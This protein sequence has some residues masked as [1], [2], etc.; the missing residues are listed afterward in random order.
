M[1]G[2]AQ[3]I[4]SLLLSGM[5]A[6]LKDSPQQ[7]WTPLHYAAFKGH[8]AAIDALL[9]G[10][11]NPNSPD[12][13]QW[14]PAHI[15]A[16]EGQTAALLA[17]LRGGASSDSRTGN[18]NTPLHVAAQEG[19]AQVVGVLLR[20][21]P[22]SLTSA[23][24][25]G[26][27][28]L[29]C[30][31]YKGR[32]AA[33]QALLGA[34]ASATAVDNCGDAPLHRT[35]AGWQKEELQQYICTAKALLEAG[36]DPAAANQQ[37]QTPLALASSRG[38]GPLLK[39]LAEELGPQG[40]GNAAGMTGTRPNV[41]GGLVGLQGPSETKRNLPDGNGEEGISCQPRCDDSACAAAGSLAGWFL[42]CHAC[43]FC[44][45]QQVKL[46]STPLHHLNP[47]RPSMRSAPTP[48][49][50]HLWLTP[51]LPLP[52]TQAS[53]KSCCG[54]LGKGT[55]AA[56]RACSSLVPQRR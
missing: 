8:A 46:R 34:G 49:L 51:S 38:F 4:R 26:Q 55:L 28:P 47:M 41:P 40:E 50:V 21:D 10:G 37:C 23:N 52:V 20:E 15:A 13:R 32:A 16:Q 25:S 18:G 30:A 35:V 48:L 54:C 31:A 7:G 9:V 29:H 3:A 56:C 5:S 2:D 27:Q 43:L 1:R 14:A 19:H 17:L 11:A 39:Q 33:V 44:K 42:S 36:A 53:A 12:R 6:D 22:T 45:H 24:S